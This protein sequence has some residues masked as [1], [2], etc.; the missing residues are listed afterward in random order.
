VTQSPHP[1]EDRSAL[2]WLRSLEAGGTRLV[3]VRDAE[4]HTSY[5]GADAEAFTGWA[6]A[7]FADRL[8]SLAHP[9]DQQRLFD[10][11]R[12]L[13]IDGEAEARTRARMEAPDGWFRWFDVHLLNR[14]DD[15]AIAGLVTVITPLRRHPERADRWAGVLARTSELVIIQRHDFR[16]GYVSPSVELLL[17]ITADQLVLRWNELMP[18]EDL[19]I[20]EETRREVAAESRGEA[21]R[22]LRIW[23]ADGS[24]RT[25]D[26]TFAN[27]LDDGLIGG[28][29]IRA[30]DVSD[31]ASTEEQ[32]DRTAARFEALVDNGPDA[33]LLLDADGVIQFCSAGVERLLGHRPQDITGTN[34]IDMVHPDDLDQALV[35]LQMLHDGV[36]SPDRTFR[37]RRADGSYEWVDITASN[38]LDDP[39]LQAL[40]L[41]IRDVSERMDADRRMQRLL[42]DSSGAA[43]VVDRD[44][45]VTWTTPGFERFIGGHRTLNAEV[46]GELFSGHD[47]DDDAVAAF[48]RVVE[49]GPGT[50]ARVV[51]RLAPTE[52]KRWADVTFTNAL[53]DPSIDGVIVNIRDVD[54]AVRAA[55]TGHRL[56]EVLESTTDFV[57]VFNRDG[58]LIWANA[59]AIGVVGAPPMRQ[60]VFV[61]RITPWSLVVLERE[62]APTLRTQN[63][64]R[65]ELALRSGE[66]GEIPMEVT[67]LNHR[68]S[69]GLEFT[70][71][72]ARDISERKALEAKLHAK[73]RHDPLTGLPNRALL[74]E[75]LELALASDAAVGLAFIDLDQFKVVND[76]QG[77]DA[78]DRLLVAA[79]DR[80]RGAV[81]PT[82]L[83]ARFGGD[84]FVVLLNGVDGVD[85]A[86][87]MASRILD[88]LRGTVRIGAMEVYLTGSAGVA[89]ADGT[90][91]DAA[92]LISNADA[93]MYKAKALGRDQVA[94]FSAELRAR[95]VE[96]METANELRSTLESDGLDV[97]FQPI[98]DTVSGLPIS[99]EALARWEHPE[100]GTVPASRFIP[101]AEETGLIVPL[102]SA[103]IRRTCEAIRELGDA[104]ETYS[105]SVNLSAYQ[106]AD[107]TLIDVF[108]AALDQFGIA[109][110][111]LYCEVTESAVMEDVT[112]SARLLDQIRA[113]GI[114]IAVD[115]FGTGYSSLAYLHRFPVDVLKIDREFV[116]G[117]AYDT[118][119]ERSL[120]AGIISLA[121]SLGLTVV[122]EGVETAEQA[123]I[124]RML[125]CDA[126]QGFLFARPTP[127]ADL[128]V[129]LE[130]M[131]ST[132]GRAQRTS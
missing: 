3:L 30:R 33:S 54:E 116:A 119:W 85:A 78:G 49:G 84:E 98:V 122:A 69:S 10:A 112:N 55:E 74:T 15:P 47:E 50:T 11:S 18:A 16:T 99:L 61:E 13:R 65:G 9:E 86:Q 96:R 104:A 8:Y 87:A 44:Y 130:S 113:L 66:H 63:T 43:F 88:D 17:G 28:L 111:Q 64:W 12:A 73:A 121:H 94:V 129:T 25:F 103:I 32:L 83:V 45:E 37:V 36:A 120:A 76:S 52:T 5:V 128:L 40:V 105:F 107:P 42:R 53:D 48:L 92:T 26:V 19:G 102:G 46:V 1:I 51:G 67:I 21:R 59:A 100:R 115:D 93:A 109:P 123:E 56:T 27:H 31:L 60:S 71:A 89:V 14:L 79:V 62:V 29:L 127:M 90:D 106:L 80:L 23:R 58:D 72:I 22:R 114:G 132:Q 24:L 7:D 131:S 70:S 38:R 124:L 118:D 81:R 68:S 39:R 125:H 35:D 75:R 77:H 2:D 6:P 57:L 41:S 34:A 97:W 91:V 117:L 20:F 4:R 126:M 101:V 95:T 110:R 82:D 108:G